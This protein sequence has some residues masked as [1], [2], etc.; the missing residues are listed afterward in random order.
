MEQIKILEKGEETM[1]QNTTLGK[2]VKVLVYAGGSA[3]LVAVATTVINK[4]E[5][6]NPTMVVFANI[7]IV[8]AKNFLDPKVKDW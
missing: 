3:L 8:V 6:F 7:A 1:N 4:P 5:L 2:G